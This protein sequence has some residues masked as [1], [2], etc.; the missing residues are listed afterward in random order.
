MKPRSCILGIIT[1]NYL[2]P[3]T[4]QQKTN[5]KILDSFKN[6]KGNYSARKLSAFVAVATSIYI[7]ARLIPEAAQ[8]D[9][10]YAWLI[11]AA[12][13][14]GIVTVEQIV[15]LRSNTQQPKVD[16]RE[17]GAGC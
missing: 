17:E 2:L 14:M 15:N 8:I 5:M 12:V 13:C 10:L 4:Q 11:F 1:T 7:T 3:A 9:A 6:I 16:M